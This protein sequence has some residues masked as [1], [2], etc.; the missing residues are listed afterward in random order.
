MGLDWGNA[1]VIRAILT[2]STAIP[3]LLFASAGLWHFDGG[4]KSGTGLVSIASLLGFA[5]A[6][7][8]IWTQGGDYVLW[9]AIGVALQASSLFLFGWSI[10]TSGRKNFGLALNDNASS[11]LVTDGPYALVRHPF[12]TSYI[13]FWTGTAAAASSI[14]T[15]FSAVA[16]LTIYFYT[17]RREDKLL[18]GTFEDEFPDWHKH[19]GAFFPKWR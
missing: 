16:L 2:V 11:K 14:F 19:T 8:S 13:I 4:H 10:G 6:L 5:S 15:I 7:Y 3:F 9:P 18:A 1:E 17:S 12:Y